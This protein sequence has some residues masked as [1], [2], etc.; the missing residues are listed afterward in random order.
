MCIEKGLPQSDSPFLSYERDTLLKVFYDASRTLA[1]ADAERSETIFAA[2]FFQAVEQGYEDTSA[3]CANRMTEGDS[4]A[5]DVDFAHVKAEFT[6]AVYSLSCESFVSFDE[7]EVFD[8]EA[9][10]SQ[11]FAGRRNRAGTHDSGINTSRCIAYDF[12]HRFEAEFFGFISGHNYESSC[13]VVDAGSVAGRDRA[14]LDE[15]RTQFCEGFHRA[16]RADEFVFVNDDVAFSLMNRYWY[17][18]A[19]EFAFLLSFVSQVFGT[20]CQFI[21]VFT[22][23]TEASGNVFSR[24]A[25]V[26]VVF[27]A[28]QAVTHEQIFEDA[29]THTIAAAAFCDGVRSVGHGFHAAC[30][31]DVGIAEFDLLGSEGNSTHTG[32]AELIQ[33]ESRN[34]LGNAGMKSNLTSRVF[35]AA[36]L[37]YVAHDNFVDLVD[38]NACAFDCFSNSSNTKVNSGDVCEL[39]IEAADGRTAS[40]YDN[41]ISH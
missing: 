33:C 10:F 31:D 2:D 29:V 27:C 32:T 18:L 11:R 19:V 1:A 9:C 39:A 37:E 38:R 6:A 28:E 17:D 40:T 5:M 34:F 41:S 21:L 36:S 12:S 23:Y 22:G 14:V 24:Y 26:V 25:H 30:Y 7:V 20:A 4:T 16:V 13:A 8:F 35:T 3:G 15:G